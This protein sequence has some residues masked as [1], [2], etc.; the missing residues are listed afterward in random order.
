MDNNSTY[1]T[2]TNLTFSLDGARVG[3]F[4]YNPD[5]SGSY[6]YNTLVYA[7][8]SVPNGNHTF[9]IHLP[10]GSADTF[11]LFDYVQYT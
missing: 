7:N 10:R 8:T 6:L 9:V 3:S 1:I 4:S 2:Y 5:G 11:A